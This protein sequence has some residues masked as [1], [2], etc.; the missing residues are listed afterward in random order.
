[1]TELIDVNTVIDRLRALH[2]VSSDSALAKVLNTPT[3]TVSS[4]R[5][6]QR[7][8]FDECVE[9]VRRFHVSFDWLLLGV[10]SDG[11]PAASNNC[12]IDR[13][14]TGHRV[15]RMMQFLM[16]WNVHR[17]PDEMAWLEMHLARTVPEYAEWLRP[18]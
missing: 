6:R 7:V 9:A 10:G 5:T 15:Q 1:M 18:A 13:D 8:P 3:T 17:T 16:H 2:G 11:Q 4:W 12:G 14:A